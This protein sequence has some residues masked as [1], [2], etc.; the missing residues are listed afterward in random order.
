MLIGSIPDSVISL[1][2]MVVA[3]RIGT[4]AVAGTGLASYLFFVM[5][6]VMSIFMV[7][8]LVYC[9]QAFGAGR[10]DL[11]ERAVGESLLAALAI[12]AAVLATSYIW[13]RSYTEILSG[14]QEGVS[15]V[16][17]AYL[18]FRILSI[19]ALMVSS[20]LA[21]SYRAVDMPWIPAYSSI[22]TGVS[23]AVLIPSLGLGYLHLPRLGVEGLGVA[24]ALSQYVGLALYAFFKPP[25]K[26]RIN[27]FSRTILKVLAIGFP[28]S[29]ERVVGS[30]GQNIYIN[31]VAKSGVKALAAHNIGLS[32]EGVLINP[33]FAVSIAASARVGQRVGSNEFER[34][35]SL[36]GEAL[37]IGISWMAVAT[38]LLLAISPVAG[39][40]FTQDPH[41]AGLVT[42][43]LVL[44]AISEIGFGGSLAL[45]GVIRGMGSTWVPLAVNSFTVL[46]LRAAL[47]QVLQPAYGIYGVWFTQITDMYG[48]FAISYALYERFKS[49]LL[50]K[51]VR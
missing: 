35:D 18:S 19:P 2:S 7:G 6:A 36:V 22:A 45:Y 43:Y 20:V 28:A 1:V 16:A 51:L 13:L 23:S 11:V 17:T 37:K 15:A 39:S 4:E 31:A 32:I 47:A 48:R 42:V 33:V 38:A 12:S 27:I 8:L 25:F 46:V 9:S 41:V 14:G 10:R 40:F 24:S 3:S 29:V 49:K 26:L 21:S 44:A 34:L 30:L 5:N 50:V